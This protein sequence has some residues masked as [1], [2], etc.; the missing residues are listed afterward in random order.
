MCTLILTNA[1]VGYLNML[2]TFIAN[3]C[4]LKGIFLKLNPLFEF[5]EK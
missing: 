4:S 1:I 2:T 5:V 3:K